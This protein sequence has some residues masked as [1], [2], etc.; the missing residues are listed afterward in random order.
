[1]ATHRLVEAI[2]KE[3]EKKLSAKG[4]DL[5][6]LSCEPVETAHSPTLETIDRKQI[7]KSL[8]ESIAKVLRQEDTSKNVPVGDLS[9]ARR[10][11][12]HRI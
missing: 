11:R 1:M 5:K 10:R 12:Y 9:A 2:Q 4:I 3:F 6:E 8:A 7:V